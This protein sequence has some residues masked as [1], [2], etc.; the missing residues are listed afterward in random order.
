MYPKQRIFNYRTVTL[1]KLREIKI[2]L[3][4]RVTCH[5]FCFLNKIFQKVQVAN[6]ANTH[7]IQSYIMSDVNM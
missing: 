4:K 5:I 7:N 6:E 3:Q 2:T 1:T